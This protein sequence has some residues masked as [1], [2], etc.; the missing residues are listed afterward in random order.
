MRPRILIIDDDPQIHKLLTKMLSPARFDVVN[1]MSADE[2]RAQIAERQP[3]LIILDLMMPK[4]SGEQLCREIKGDKRLK[5]ILV[6]ILT[7]KEG[8]ADRIAGLKLGADDYITKP[9]YM[10]SLVRK[11]DYMLEKKR[12]IQDV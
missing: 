2:G 6:L 11:V 8:Q 7:A 9:F 10:A 12:E 5:D 4:V 3:D 1:A